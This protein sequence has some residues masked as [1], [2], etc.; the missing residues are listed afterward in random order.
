[1]NGKARPLPCWISFSSFWEA[2]KPGSLLMAHSG[3]GC[4]ASE[5]LGSGWRHR[6]GDKMSPSPDSKI[7]LC[8]QGAKHLATSFLLNICFAFQVSSFRPGRTLQSRLERQN[9]HREK[10]AST[11]ADQWH[12]RLR[13]KSI[14]Q[15]GGLWDSQ[16]EKVMGGGC[17]WD[18]PMCVRTCV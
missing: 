12:F 15:I 8:I 6:E 7:G 18:A 13:R 3:V 2:G 11:W 1:M 16:S 14:K 10:E 5:H 17:W 4:A 9:S